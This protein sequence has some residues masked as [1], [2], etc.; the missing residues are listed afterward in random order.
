MN[1]KMMDKTVRKNLRDWFDY[2]GGELHRFLC[3]K[4][5]TRDAPDL[6]QDVYLRVLTYSAVDSIREPKSFLFRIAANLAVDHLRKRAN[7][8]IWDS[9]ALNEGD[10]VEPSGPY[11]MLNSVERM[12]GFSAALD[13]LPPEYRHAF[14]LNRFDGLSHAE[15]ARCMGVS[16]KTVQRYIAKAFEHCLGALET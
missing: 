16:P 11:E 14:L 1:A 3:R 10:H 5:G 12:Q 6:V 7:R 13:Q 9:E 4:V 8:I 2:Y 15:I